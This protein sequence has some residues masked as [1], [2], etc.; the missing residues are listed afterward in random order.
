MPVLVEG[1]TVIVRFNAIE[2]H[3][4]GGWEAFTSKCPNNSLCADGDL[5][6]VGFMTPMDTK[7]F[8]NN[9]SSRG[10]TYL[11]NGEAQDLVVADQRRGFPVECEWA[12]LLQM[13]A[14]GK[15]AE[16]IV[17]CRLVGSESRTVAVP[18]GWA[19]EG[20]LSAN[21]GYVDA[22]NASDRLQ[23]LRHEDGVDVYRDT[24]T[25]E[26]VYVGRGLG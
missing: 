15:E 4:P 11:E 9:L 13:P 17:V 25:G 16:Q 23:F 2:E 24:K 19:Y 22:E 18:D 14:P 12:E 7:K 26:E 10:L 5:A 1:V 20:S 21:V 8:V 3:Y 6:R